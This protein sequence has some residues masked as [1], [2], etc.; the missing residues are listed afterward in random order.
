MA[1]RKRPSEEANP[2]VETRSAKTRRT[3]TADRKKEKKKKPS[4]MDD[5]QKENLAP[6]P[7]DKVQTSASKRG[8]RRKDASPKRAAPANEPEAE[9]SD[10]EAHGHDEVRV[11]VTNSVCNAHDVFVG[12]YGGQGSIRIHFDGTAA[13]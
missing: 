12:S 8:R 7:P 2:N 3:S 4:K 10:E 11:R 9:S 5:V 1:P 6:A 13:V